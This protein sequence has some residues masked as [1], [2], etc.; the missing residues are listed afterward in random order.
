[1]ARDRLYR[2]GQPYTLTA[3]GDGQLRVRSEHLNEI[4][5]KTRVD[6]L[7]DQ[8]FPGFSPARRSAEYDRAPVDPSACADG[9][10]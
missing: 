3:H 1:M 9:G 7:G 10:R 8:G 2:A 6:E 4:V 5:A